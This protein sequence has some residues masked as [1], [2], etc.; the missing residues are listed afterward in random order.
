MGYMIICHVYYTHFHFQINTS[1]RN[2]RESTFCTKSQIVHCLWVFYLHSRCCSNIF[3]WL[4]HSHGMLSSPSLSSHCCFSS[5][6]F[7]WKIITC[8]SHVVHGTLQ[9]SACPIVPRLAHPSVRFICDS[10]CPSDCLLRAAG[11]A[12]RSGGPSSHPLPV[13][14]SECACA[15]VQECPADKGL[16]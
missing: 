10:F 16:S 7:Y 14:C 9:L 13:K 8:Y 6:G 3:L 15:C 5:L 4:G 12:R 1:S 2:N 11:H